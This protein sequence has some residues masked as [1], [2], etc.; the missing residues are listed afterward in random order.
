MP[1]SAYGSHFHFPEE[2]AEATARFF[3]AY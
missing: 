2:F 3:V 1:D